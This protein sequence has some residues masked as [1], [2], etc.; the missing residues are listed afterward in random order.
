MQSDNLTLNE[1]QQKAVEHKDGPMM[2]LAGPGSGKT[3]VITQRV[4]YLIDTHY[5]N[6]A[7]ILVITFTKAAAGEMKERFFRLAGRR[8]LPVTFGTFH[9]VFF[10][11]LKY[12]YG[13]RASDIVQEDQRFQFMKQTAARMRLDYEDENDF[14]S[15]LLAEIS[16][17]KNSGIK[18]EHY[19]ATS[20]GEDVFRQ[21]YAAYQN[22][23]QT[24]HL[25]DFDDMLVYCKELFEQRKDI[26]AGWQKRYPYILIDE[27]QDINQVQYE[28]VKMLAGK[29]QNL[30]LV[31]DDDQSIYRF[32][33]A[34]PEIMLH[35]EKDFP[36]L[37]KIVLNKNYR[38]P[39]EIVRLSE[40]LISYNQVRFPKK[41]SAVSE[42]P[43]MIRN[44]SFP[45]QKEENK[46]LV[47]EILRKARQGISYDDM[48]VLFRTNQQPRLLMEYLMQYNIPFR[49]KEKIPNIYDHWITKDILCYIK[50]AQG[51]RQRSDFLRIMNRPK[52]YLSR[53]SL[54]YDTVAFDVWEE[55]Y[56]E[57][58]WMVQRLHKLEGDLEMIRQMKPYS[59][60]NYI[61]KA[62]DYEG[63][64]R[65]IAQ[66]RHIDYEELITVLD[67]LQEGARPFTTYEAWYLH[68]DDVKEKLK[69]RQEEMET[70]AVT[71]STFHGVKGLEYDYV[72][73]PDINEG[74]LPYRKSVLDADIEEER[75]LFYV[76]ITRSKKELTLCH[77]SQINNREMKPSRFL[78][79]LADSV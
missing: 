79:E 37:Q 47:S 61:R 77:C 23:L 34:K 2:V 22:F 24:S 10:M 69:H 29:K 63:Y 8:S 6:P 19:Y 57:A 53:D 38:S 36:M 48:V 20:C 40:R 13:Y 60:V 76:G 52:R 55:Y 42:Y 18:M 74:I 39:E 4:K 64:L 46:Y 11:I 58:E 70:E 12:A 73:I 75:R 78:D 15:S 3:A 33:G 41:V 30:F 71:L 68:M 28:I 35:V 1:M 50:I 25:I 54:P 17:V 27:F 66:I 44:L 14:I 43:G 59:A 72:Y 7:S 56:E 51:S 21:M 62:V 67:E 49:T 9:A 26:L 16:M 31:G 5:V 32:R 45:H 65:E